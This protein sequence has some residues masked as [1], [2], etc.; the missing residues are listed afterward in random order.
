M[1]VAFSEIM[2]S[3]SGHV[4]RCAHISGLGSIRLDL[5]K[6]QNMQPIGPIGRWRFPN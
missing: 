1:P 5:A 6:L 2:T 4:G 3:F